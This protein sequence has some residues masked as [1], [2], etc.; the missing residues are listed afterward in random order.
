MGHPVDEKDNQ[1]LDS[2]SAIHVLKKHKHI[3]TM[4]LSGRL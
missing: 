2:S 3:V 1:W 4:Y